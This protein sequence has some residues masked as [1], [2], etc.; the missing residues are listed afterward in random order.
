MTPLP[1]DAR[2]HKSMCCANSLN[3]PEKN[4]LIAVKLQDFNALINSINN[5]SSKGKSY[6]SQNCRLRALREFNKND[7]F[8]DYIDLYESL[9]N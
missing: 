9:I 4:N 6:Y 7:R 3:L 8:K 1:T 5:I 2:N